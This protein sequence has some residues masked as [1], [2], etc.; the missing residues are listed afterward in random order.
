[1]ANGGHRAVTLVLA[2]TRTPAAIRDALR[3]GRTVAWFKQTVIGRPANVEEVV[4]ASL[5]VEAGDVVEKSRVLAF[6]LKNNSPIRYTLRRKG[7]QA[8]YNSA[9]VVVVPPFGE[10]AL[11]VTGG[12]TPQTLELDFEVLNSITAPKQ[13]LSLTLRPKAS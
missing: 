7:G 2:P 8:F 9:D 6:K 13:T 3:A 10:V 1:V 5:S 4:R 11:Q 12:V